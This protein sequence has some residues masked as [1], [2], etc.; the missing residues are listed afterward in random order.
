MLLPDHSLF[1]LF[2]YI[3]L[4]SALMARQVS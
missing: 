4:N 1:V 2:G 3:H